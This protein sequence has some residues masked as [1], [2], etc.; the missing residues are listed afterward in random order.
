IGLI[1]VIGRNPITNRKLAEDT[2]N[3]VRVRV[4]GEL[5]R[6][7]VE[8]ALIESE[9]RFKALHNASFG[10][11]A[12]HDN[13]VILDCNQGL[14]EMMGYTREELITMD[15][16]LLI[17]PDSRQLILDMVKADY[18][19]PYEA[20]GLRKNGE[21]FPMR[22][23]A[24]SIP[25]KGQT[26]R[27]VEFRDLTEQK[28]AEKK[29]RESEEDLKESQRIAHVGNWHLDVAS[30][31]V[32]WSEELYRMYGFDPSLPP[33][34]YTEHQKLFTRESWERL[35]A[36][37]AKTAETGIPYEMELNTIRDDG[38]YGWMW[39]HGRVVLDETG[40]TLG[41]KGV[42]QD[43]SERKHSEQEKEKLQSSLDQA[44]KMD[45]VGQLAGGVAHDFNNLLTVIMGYSAELCNSLPPDSQFIPDVEEI[46]KAGKRA[47][48]LTQQL[49][50]FSRK[51]MIQ[52]MVL[53]LNVII[54]NLDKMLRR[55]IGEHIELVNLLANE[56]TLIMA[57]SG[58]MEQVI[59]NLVVNSRDAMPKGGKITVQTS[60]LVIDKVNETSFQADPGKYVLLSVT[61]NGKGM[62]KSTISKVFE[63]FFTTKEKGSGLGLGLSTVYGIVM[64]SGGKLSVES[65]PGKGTSIQI[66]LPYATSETI[67]EQ[68]PRI[69]TDTLGKGEQILIVEDEESLCLY[70]NRMIS[71]LGYKVTTA[72]SGAEALSLLAAG[73]KPDLLITDV[74][75][76]GMNGQELADQ[77]R[78]NNPE[79]K[80]MFMSG[81]TDDIII[82]FGV[83]NPGIHFIQKPFSSSE[84]AA[85]I[86]AV[87]NDYPK[88]QSK[89]LKI[90]ML[91][92]EKDILVL[93]KRVSNKRGHEFTGVE[94][95]DSA[96]Q[97][98]NMEKYDILL[99]DVNLGCAT[100]MEALQSIRETG[101]NLPAIA[102][103]GSLNPAH[104]EAMQALGVARYM[105]KSFELV[106]LIEA[107]E[108][109]VMQ[110]LPSY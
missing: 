44:R 40:K 14:S 7:D 21:I 58:Q 31:E 10:G 24:R 27:S 16:Y 41:L 91:D 64:Q 63:P 96:L 70:F 107:A 39:V 42:A 2:L 106:Q 93:V 77:V 22:L 92:D 100:G 23:E 54:S 37:L 57:D 26:V 108:D 12:I 109:V 30:N 94:D 53:D 79:Q 60:I 32:V 76:S 72:H 69:N 80:L 28:I 104:K 75:M 85:R 59:I 103:S 99:V 55:L 43:I 11:I 48:D 25:Y 1:A 52:A 84:I 83:L 86:S 8:K 29:L 4:A 20:F 67:I 15:G 3:Y 88:P 73:L 19:K 89:K 47:K 18:H 105:E 49:L 66:L 46:L 68:K 9:E 62:D 17:A 38:Y 87:L 82:P 34:P 5:E 102:I 78:L 56:H 6:L 71:R 95:V 81:F 61:D 74:I 97:A 35:S 13:G 90:L 101:H 51:Q 98:L 33:P 50:T 110:L 65:E 45:L 36:A